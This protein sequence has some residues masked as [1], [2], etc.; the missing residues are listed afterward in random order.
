MHVSTNAYTYIYLVNYCLFSPVADLVV[1]YE[2]WFLSVRKSSPLPPTPAT[3]KYLLGWP[4]TDE[5]KS[6]HC[7]NELVI[8]R[9]KKKKKKKVAV[10]IQV[11]H[12]DIK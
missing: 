6:P 2:V 4:T 5:F 8:E 12:W 9:R 3:Q 11:S 10:K 1:A 7:S